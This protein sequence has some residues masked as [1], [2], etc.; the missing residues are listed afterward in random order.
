MFFVV[1]LVVAHG[2]EPARQRG[3]PIIFSEPK[4]DTV[5][6]NLNQLDLKTSPFKGLESDLKK[7]FEIFDSGRS[8]GSFRPPSGLI[9]PPATPA[10]NRRIKDLIDKRAEMMLPGPDSG[11]PDL[12]GDDPF[13]PS[14]DTVDA[15]GRKLKTPLDRYYNRLDRERAAFTNQV[16]NTDLFGKNKDTDGK[17]QFSRPFSDKSFGGDLKASGSS[18]G[19]LSNNATA[20]SGFFSDQRKP[21]TFEELLDLPRPNEPT[22]RSSGL[23]ETRLDEFKRLLDRPAFTPS[24]NSYSPGLPVA[25][26]ELRPVPASPWPTWSSS[27]A[28]VNPRDSF[29]SQAG[30]G[31]V[32][33]PYQLQNLPSLAATTPSLN[34]TPPPVLKPKQPTTSFSIPKRQ[35]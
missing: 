19:Q 34:P 10:N 4:S 1:G 9:T 25:G 2:Q 21:K 11:D 24:T 28:P 13:K 14:E 27:P 22:E 20:S 29:T 23:K 7:P 31:L 5:S 30:L 8:I 26:A 33:A 15:T 16:R 17:D 32:G 3:T 35:F 18:S 6:S 12:T